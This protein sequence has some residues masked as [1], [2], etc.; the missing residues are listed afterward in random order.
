[1]K[2]I[3]GVSDMSGAIAV[4]KSLKGVLEKAMHLMQYNFLSPRHLALSVSPRHL[5]LSKRF[6]K[7]K[8]PSPLSRSDTWRQTYAV[9]H[10]TS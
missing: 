6:V 10:T 4:L 5:A 9:V 2:A 8:L 1:M 7:P 3:L